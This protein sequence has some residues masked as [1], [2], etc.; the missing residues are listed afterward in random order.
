VRKAFNL[1]INRNYI[2]NQFRTGQKP[3]SGLV[4]Y[5]TVDAAGASSDFRRIGGDYYSVAS[6]DYEKN[7][8]EARRLL[9]EAGYPDGVGFPVIEY[10]YRASSRNRVFLAEVLP[11]MW[12]TVLGVTVVLKHMNTEAYNHAF[13]IG[14]F[15]LAYDGW[16]G[17]YNDPENFLGVF[18]TGG[19][20]NNAQYH[21]EAF[22]SLIKQARSIAI[23]KERMR[24]LH[25]A[26][27]LLIGQ[28]TA[29]FPVFFH[30]DMYLINPRLS[31]FYYS[32]LGY[33]YFSAVQIR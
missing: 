31:G 23:P 25:Q 19:G 7:G 5:G 13:N 6:A 28:D 29:I 17:D 30:T 11:H 21:N 1:A 2:V 15:S 22:D 9:A 10:L 20:N 32:P 4:P 26:E 18:L 24:L 14:N 33:L 16:F 27:D 8:A 12:Q 3:A